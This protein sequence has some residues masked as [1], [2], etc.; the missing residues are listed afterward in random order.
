M[1]ASWIRMKFPNTFDGAIAASAPIVQF[2][3][4]KGLDLGQFF[5]LTTDNYRNE[6]GCSDVIREAY[7]RI[8]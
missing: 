7:N 5:K 6:A 2:A 4:R 3:N 8:H 1:M